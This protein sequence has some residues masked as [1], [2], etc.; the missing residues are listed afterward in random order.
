MKKTLAILCLLLACS[1]LMPGNACSQK[2][3][4]KK[5][6][7]SIAIALKNAYPACVQ[8]FA[9]DTLAN[10]QAGGVFSGVVVSKNGYI[11]TAAHVEKPGVIYKVN[12]V[13]GRACL[14]RG[15]GEIILAED[16]TIPDAAILSIITP[17]TWPFAEMGSSSALRID[18][19][20]I[21]I[22]YPESLGQPKPV[23]RFGYVAE[24]K[25]TRG[26]IR[27]TCLMEP[28]DSGGPLFDCEGRVIGIHSAIEPSEESN[29]D[30]PVDVYKKYWTALTK[31]PQVYNK[32]PDVT[33]NVPAEPSSATIA[34]LPSLVNN[35]LI[36]DDAEKLS[37]NCVKIVSA[38]GGKSQKITG[39][40]FS[41]PGVGQQGYQSLI[42]T[43]NSLIGDGPVITCSN[44]QQIGARVIARDKKHDLV[45]LQPINKV[46]GG[47]SHEQLSAAKL[48]VVHAG[49]FLLSPQPDTAAIAGIS[50]SAVFAMPKVSSVGFLGVGFKN[51]TLPL[52]V[53]Y[54][55][56][57]LNQSIYQVKT[58]DEIL[59][60]NGQ[61]VVD[62]KGIK[63]SLNDYWP[64]DTV[65]LKL[66]RGDSVFTRDIILDT[67]PQ[68]HF[69]HPA[70]LLAGGKSI[71]RDGFA[72][73]FTQDAIERP[74]Q[75]GGPVFDMEGNFYGINI[76][77]FS[78]ASCLVL[79]AIVVSDFINS[80]LAPE[81]QSGVLTDN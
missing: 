73:V 10:Q 7:R 15:L 66:K 44:S 57:N 74:D 76:A 11:L 30:V 28:G 42:V 48:N 80:A 45:L 37:A 6:E 21:S 59:A 62:F 39:A 35:R 1:L 41:F 69:N 50:G 43:K 54:V 38:I 52:N 3:A 27:S 29:Y 79:P 71:R 78:R 46:K 13:D 24:V 53:A 18:E 60:F 68:K 67:L 20:C 17:G 65:K 55:F 47:I 26:F 33:D 64:G 32:Y 8:L 40:L 51:N 4:T 12:F 49:T 22:S 75:C 9:Y 36:K 31:S 34:S 81:K 25:N 14:A 56:P 63:Q 77:R 5:L 72:S 23:L 2:A 19:P 61:P 58:G 16:K 70:E